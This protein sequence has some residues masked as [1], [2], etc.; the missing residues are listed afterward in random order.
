MAR[1][2]DLPPKMPVFAP[3]PN[4]NVKNFPHLPTVGISFVLCLSSSII[5]IALLVVFYVRMCLH[6]YVQLQQQETKLNSFTG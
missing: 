6:I 1:D 5:P 4:R 2:L 3:I